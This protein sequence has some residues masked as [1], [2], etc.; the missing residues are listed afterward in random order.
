MADIPEQKANAYFDCSRDAKFLCKQLTVGVPDLEYAY[1][2]AFSSK[3]ENLKVVER[4]IDGLTPP[5]KGSGV[6]PA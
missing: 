2:D 6:L 5:C 3:A 4:S 1:A